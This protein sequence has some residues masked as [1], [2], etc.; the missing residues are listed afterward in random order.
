M[1]NRRGTYESW[2]G[3]SLEPPGPD[4][5]ATGRGGMGRN[6]QRALSDAG[7]VPLSMETV[8]YCYLVS[9]CRSR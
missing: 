1:G 8:R 6:D 9:I 2:H 7:K 3:H 4:I 5:G